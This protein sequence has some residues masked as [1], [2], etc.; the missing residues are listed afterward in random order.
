M[1][2]MIDI[3]KVFRCSLY[4]GHLKRKWAVSSSSVPQVHVAEVQ[5]CIL[6][7]YVASGQCPVSSCDNWYGT[8]WRQSRIFAL[9]AVG[10]NILVTG[11]PSPEAHSLSHYAF[12]RSLMILFRWEIGSPT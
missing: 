11:A 1:V 5:S 8:T 2:D 9:A 12:A 7:K 10:K 4:L 6:C 3:L